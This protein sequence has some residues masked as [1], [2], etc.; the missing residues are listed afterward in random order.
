MATATTGEP[1]QN[2]FGCQ[3]LGNLEKEKTNE[4]EQKVIYRGMPPEPQK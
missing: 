1:E 4:G 3:V 2:G